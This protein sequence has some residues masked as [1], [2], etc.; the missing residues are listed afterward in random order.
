MVEPAIN[1]YKLF[2]SKVPWTASVR[3]LRQY[4]QQFGPVEQCS[5]PFNKLTGFHKGYC[6]VTFTTKTGFD[7]ALEK[8]IHVLEGT[9][10][11]VQKSYQLVEFKPREGDSREM[12]TPELM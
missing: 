8:D 9:K 6:H 11:H 1:L 3:E 7:S 5:L 2:V 10:L 12:D 4:F